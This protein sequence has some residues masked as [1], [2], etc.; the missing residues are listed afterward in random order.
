[1]VE[2]SAKHGFVF[3][4]KPNND[5][6]LTP[7]AEHKWTLVWLHGLGDTAEGFLNQFYSDNSLVPNQKTKVILLNSPKQPVTMFS[8]QVMNSWYNMLEMK[9]EQYI[10]DETSV[11]KSTR[12]IT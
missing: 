7:V 1:M 4:R 2:S 5:I 10:I 11:A 12:R 8:G 6:Y 3:D 9:G